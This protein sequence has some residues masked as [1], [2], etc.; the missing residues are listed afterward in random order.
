MAQLNY[1]E[2]NKNDK[3]IVDEL[4]ALLDQVDKIRQ[5]LYPETRVAG[6]SCDADGLCAH[7][8]GVDNRLYSAA[9]EITKAI[10]DASRES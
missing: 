7:H 3:R 10:R 5:G 8:A 1:E 2:L 9:D 6:C 4:R